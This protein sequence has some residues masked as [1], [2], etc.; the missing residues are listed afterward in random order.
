MCVVGWG[1][2]SLVVW[3]GTRRL[4][5]PHGAPTIWADFEGQKI[6]SFE[7]QGTSLGHWCT[8]GTGMLNWEME[9][10]STDVTTV[11]L[12]SCA[13]GRIIYFLNPKVKVLLGCTSK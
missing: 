5:G 12:H 11:Y 9:M 3:F 7:L 6:W 2:G 4:F 13:T 1:G 10:Q 8:G